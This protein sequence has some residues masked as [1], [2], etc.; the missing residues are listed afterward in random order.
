VEVGHRHASDSHGWNGGWRVGMS[1]PVLYDTVLDG[2]LVY[3]V[4]SYPIL[5]DT[6][7]GGSLVYPFLSY[8]ILYDTVLDAPI[9]LQDHW[10]ACRTVPHP[11]DLAW[12]DARNP[13]DITFS[14]FEED[15]ICTGTIPRGMATPLPFSS[16]MWGRSRWSPVLAASTC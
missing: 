9:P 7:L 6:V 5:Y 8:P 13:V 12:N 4:L 15:W 10:C 14:T 16:D 1:C 2:S 11:R 3:P